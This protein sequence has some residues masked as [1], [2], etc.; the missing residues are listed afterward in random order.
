VSARPTFS[1]VIPTMDRP[2]ALARCLSAVDRLDYPAGGFEVIVVDDGGREPA[3]AP[4]CRVIRQANAGPAAARN[5]GAAEAAGHYVA[6]TDDDCEPAPGWL[7]AFEGALSDG[8][9]AVAGRATN[10]ARDNVCA[11]T[12]QLLIDHLL[13]HYNRNPRDARFATSNNLAADREILLAAGGFDESFL[14]AAGEDRELVHRLRAL[15]HRIAY[16]PRANVLHHHRQDLGQLW[17][18]HYGYGRAAVQVR[19]RSGGLGVE[20][21]SFYRRLLAAPTPALSG[22]LA[23]T[24]VANA[25]GFAHETIQR[26][27]S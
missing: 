7:R 10:A 24:Q 11:V 3:S 17:R 1:V 13:E 5:R 26:R 27:A 20:P 15:G 18:Q 9:V 19:A 16:E 12:G 25:A 21:L 14:R 4:G 8:A 23:L 2:R 22:L 6:F